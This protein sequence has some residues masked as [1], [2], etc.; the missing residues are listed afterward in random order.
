MARTG[1]PGSSTDRAL[2]ELGLRAERHLI[3]Q[4]VPGRMK[5]AHGHPVSDARTL[6]FHEKGLLA[7]HR[8]D[9]GATAARF[10]D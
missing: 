7:I 4:A 8:L 1:F 2:Q 3:Q 5:A 9:G 6:E 10:P